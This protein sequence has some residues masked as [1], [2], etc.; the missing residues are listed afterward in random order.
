[1]LQRAWKRPQSNVSQASFLR[2][3]TPGE[4]TLAATLPPSSR[5][6]V[7]GTT[8]ATVKEGG[9]GALP[10]HPPFSPLALRGLAGGRSVPWGSFPIDLV[11]PSVD[12]CC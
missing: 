5:F 10:S 2:G 12:E 8:R 1:L 3:Y 7:A 11:A 9:G 6:I 4:L